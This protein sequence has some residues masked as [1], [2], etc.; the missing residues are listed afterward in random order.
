MSHELQAAALNVANSLKNLGGSVS[1][2]GHEF[3][4]HYP[5]LPLGLVDALEIFTICSEILETA[6]DRRSFTMIGCVGNSES[7]ETNVD[8]D[9]IRFNFEDITF[10]LTQSKP[11][12]IVAQEEYRRSQTMGQIRTTYRSWRTTRE[13]EA[14]NDIIIERLDGPLEITPIW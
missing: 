11:R 13:C 9:V 7:L 8:F 14:I 12:L 2:H 4:K 6:C 5:P 10:Y 1:R 3:S